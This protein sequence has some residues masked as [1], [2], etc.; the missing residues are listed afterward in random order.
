MKSVWFD[1]S[2][3]KQLL[4]GVSCVDLLIRRVTGDGVT[5][6]ELA[7]VAVDHYV[8]DKME[9]TYKHKPI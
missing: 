2:A 3:A 9:R 1:L 6:V 4:E 7:G 8:L 5:E